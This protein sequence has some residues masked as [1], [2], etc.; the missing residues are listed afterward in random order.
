MGIY[1]RKPHVFSGKNVI[2]GKMTLTRK[3]FISTKFKNVAYP[4][5]IKLKMSEVTFNSQ[6]DY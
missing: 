6:T 3:K 5:S 4:T 2:S 1:T